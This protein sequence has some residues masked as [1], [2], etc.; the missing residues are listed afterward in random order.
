MMFHIFMILHGNRFILPVHCRISCW[1]SQQSRKKRIKA[2]WNSG[3]FKATYTPKAIMP[4]P[5]SNEIPWSPGRVQ[6]KGW[7][8]GYSGMCIVSIERFW[9]IE[10]K[11]FLE[12]DRLYK[13]HCVSWHI[14]FVPFSTFPSPNCPKACLP[15]RLPSLVNWKSASEASDSG[16]LLPAYRKGVSSWLPRTRQDTGGSSNQLIL[17]LSK[18]Y[19]GRDMVRFVRLRTEANNIVY[20]SFYAHWF[21]WPYYIEGYN[22]LGFDLISSPNKS[23]PLSGPRILSP[24]AEHTF[25]NPAHTWG[26]PVYSNGTV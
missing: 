15:T 6:T 2:A 13:Y 1:T 20:P 9:M 10:S 16:K 7:C 8:H 21:T 11:R 25:G 17:V 23:C 4:T 12:T 18:S 19:E 5:G 24:R 14:L 3:Q 22:F 26:P